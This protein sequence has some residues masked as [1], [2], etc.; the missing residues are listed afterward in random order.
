MS[1]YNLPLLW[2]LAGRNDVLLWLTGW[3]YASA[4]LF[5][6]WVAR[7]ATVQAIVHSAAYT[8]L[9]REYL[10]A[11]FKERYWSTGVFATVAMSLLLPLSIRQLREKAYEVFLL[12][13][14]ALALATLVLLF[15]HVEI[16]GTDY[17]GYLWACVALWA[18]DRVLRILRIALLSRRANAHITNDGALVRLTLAVPSSSVA[19]PHAGAYYFLYRPRSLAPWENHPFT[20]AAWTG[21]ELT[22]LFRAHG[23]GT[24]ALAAGPTTLLVEGPYGSKHHLGGFDRVLLVAGGSGVSAILPYAAELE[25]ATIVW[26]VRERE[27]ADGV[28]AHELAGRPADVYVSG[29]SA[30]PS[31]APPAPPAPPG[32]RNLPAEGASPPASL[33]KDEKDADA[34]SKTSRASSE[35]MYHAGRPD[36]AAVLAAEVAALVGAQRLAVLACGPAS[37][38]DDLRAAVARS[39]GSG[40]GQVGASRLAYF[41]DAFQW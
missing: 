1:F 8:W 18:F 34:S 3:S 6:R 17:N 13:H 7:I 41:E 29:E 14:I 20:V 31:A 11:S 12:I 23:K 37:M 26:A 21:G 15:Y 30:W 35:H 28:L 25:R 39:Y 19:K 2:V 22:F 27:F 16:F 10:A 5:H 33:A 32:A 38:M 40:E 24:H 36:V 9:E 4:S